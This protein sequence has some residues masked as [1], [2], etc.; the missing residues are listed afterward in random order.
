M[1]KIIVSSLH[2]REDIAREHKP[3]RMLTVMSPDPPIGPPDFYPAEQHLYVA[4]ND[5]NFPQGGLIEPR[6]HHV[7]AIINFAQGWDAEAPLHVHCWAGVSRSTASALV[8]ALARFPGLD[9]G[10]LAQQLRTLC[11]RAHPNG[12]IVQLGDDLLGR[13]GRLVDAV[14]AMG[15]GDG[16]RANE[17]IFL[18][19]KPLL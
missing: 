1:A 8:S 10:L 11:P 7:R 18:D 17:P 12:L 4:V 2:D 5:I 14:R 16:C 6:E 3:S 19:L 15:A 13:Q 9:E